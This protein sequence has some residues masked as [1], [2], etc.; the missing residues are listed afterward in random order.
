MQSGHDLLEDKALEHM[1]HSERYMY[2][3]VTI[4]SK[5]VA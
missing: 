2:L 5:V 3:N 1:M 4:S